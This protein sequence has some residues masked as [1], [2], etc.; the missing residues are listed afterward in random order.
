[1]VL[2]CPWEWI[3]RCVRVCGGGQWFF[4]FLPLFCARCSR[5]GAIIGYQGGTA[6]VRDMFSQLNAAGVPMAGM[7]LQ[8]WTGIRVRLLQLPHRC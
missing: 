8:D 6:A 2:H 5:A 1:M 3:S 4:I 7:W